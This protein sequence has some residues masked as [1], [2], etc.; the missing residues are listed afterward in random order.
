MKATGFFKTKKNTALIFYYNSFSNI[1]VFKKRQISLLCLDKTYSLA[2]NL[3]FLHNIFLAT[4]TDGTPEN[5]CGVYLI[6]ENI[7]MYT[8]VT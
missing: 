4:C 8:N 3:Q 2:F 6:A 1:A 7:D 5:G